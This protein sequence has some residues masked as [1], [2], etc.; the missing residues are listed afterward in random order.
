[1]T[2]DPTGRFATRVADYVKYR[3]GYP[4]AVLRLLEDE[5]GLGSTP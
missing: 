5:C 1:M 4:P 3:P 2:T